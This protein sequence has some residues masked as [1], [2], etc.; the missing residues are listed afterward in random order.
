M[1]SYSNSGFSLSK[2]LFDLSLEELTK[3]EVAS[4]TET[5]IHTSPAATSV[6]TYQDIQASNARSLNE[7]LEIYVP[8]LQ[9]I[10]HQYGFS[11]LGTR[12]IMSDRD[13]KY[14]LLV[15]GQVM[16]QHTIAGAI[17]ERDLLMLS[18]IKRIEV[19]RGPGSALYGLGAV[20]MVIHIE[21]FSAFEE[22]DRSTTKLGLDQNYA[23]QELSWSASLGDSAMSYFYLA[24]A[25]AEGADDADAPLRFATDFTSNW[26]DTITAGEDASVG[27]SA[28]QASYHD[29]APIKLHWQL[30]WHDATIWARYTRGGETVA[31]STL[32]AAAPPK[33][34][35]VEISPD[36]GPYAPIELGY[37]QFTLA[38]QWQQFINSRWR[39]Q[40]D[41]SYNL[42][43]Y[44]RFISIEPAAFG[45]PRV[46]SHSEDRTQFKAYGHRHSTHQ[47]LALGFE[48]SYERFGRDSPGYPQQ[49][50]S[51]ALYLNDMPSWNINV[52]S[53]VAEYQRQ[54]AQSLT[55]FIGGRTDKH[56]YSDWLL[57][58]RIG[59]VKQIDSDYLKLTLSRSQR[60]NFDG[61][62][63]LAYEA[64]NRNTDPET[65]NA[66]ELRWEHI[67]DNSWLAVSWF[68]YDL[69]VIGFKSIPNDVGNNVVIANQKQ[70]GAE[71][72]W[73]QRFHDFQFIFSHAH[74]YLLDFTL[75]D[76][77]N[78][79]ISVYPN[80][81]GKHLNNW[82]QDITKLTV[83]YRLS[84]QWSLYNAFIY[85]WGFQGIDD[86]TTWD[87]Q[88][89]PAASVL[90]EADQTEIY[91][92]NLYWNLGATYNITEQISW[93]ITG[94][95]L[96]GLFDKSLN[97]RNYFAASSAYRIQAPALTIKFEYEFE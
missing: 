31:T 11:H 96:A 68:Y 91:Q 66:L 44:E 5:A 36:V 22:S 24:A 62:L 21:T 76:E 26:G 35:S 89:L 81:F 8:G 70:W 38:S 77:G 10:K 78:S 34:R 37:Q 80:G 65:L 60:M 54:L 4:V 58:P 85:Y 55:L 17:S 69:D 51:S 1:L 20:S 97:K 28:D 19:I 27:F 63:R 61:E 74:T 23:S 82:S 15:N 30:D 12:G 14:L 41:V 6:I 49:P 73:V 39:L 50:A 42:I 84:P 64:G 88:Q 57:S 92:P 47:Q 86:W 3:V 53:L 2:H 43:D 71:F 95:Y 90:R 18:D 16:N 46:E 93:T 9:W 29:R 32:N 87:S 7:L 33:G 94:H 45:G 83:N 59:L 67:M 25:K 75:L 56:T 52:V 48:W 72:E 79:L 40:Y 13:D